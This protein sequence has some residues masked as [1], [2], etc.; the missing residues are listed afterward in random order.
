LQGAQEVPDKF[1]RLMAAIIQKKMKGKNKC[2]SD[3][4]RNDLACA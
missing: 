3:I 2:I 1:I 4:G